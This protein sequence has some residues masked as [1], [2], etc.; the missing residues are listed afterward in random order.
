MYPMFLSCFGVQAI[1]K[2]RV[3]RDKQQAC[4]RIDGNGGNGA[5]DLVVAPDS[6]PLGDVSLLGCINTNQVADSF[7]VFRV[8]TNRNVDTIFVKNRRTNKLAWP[9]GCRVFDR[10]TIAHFV[11]CRHAVILPDFL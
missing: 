6:S 8:L 5:V 11:F 2:T 10:L 9:F 4:V 1:H 3:I 7:T